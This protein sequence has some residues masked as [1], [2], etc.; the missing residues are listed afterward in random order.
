MYGTETGRSKGHE[1]AEDRNS[2][3]GRF[4]RRSNFTLL[5]GLE[6]YKLSTS[7]IVMHLDSPR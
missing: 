7:A 1:K 5:L 6:V 2:N 3:D 4:M